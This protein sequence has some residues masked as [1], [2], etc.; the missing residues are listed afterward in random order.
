MPVRKIS[1]NSKKHNTMFCGLIG[2]LDKLIL[3]YFQLEHKTGA[4]IGLAEFLSRNPDSEAK[5]ISVKDSMFTLAKTN[6]VQKD[7]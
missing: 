3:F 6:F 1:G 4:K 7:F 2:W 5:P